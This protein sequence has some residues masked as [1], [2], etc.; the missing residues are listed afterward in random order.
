MLTEG[1]VA[2]LNAS[3]PLKAML[4]GGVSPVVLPKNSPLPAITYYGVSG[5]KD[6]ALDRAAVSTDS[7]DVNAW[8]KTYST[9]K[10]IQAQIHQLLDGYSG[11]L[12]DADATRVVAVTGNDTPD[13]FDQDSGLYRCTTMYSFATTN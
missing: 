3:A 4:S 2:L 7:I 13:S 1:I 5:K 10:Q 9:A 11:T 8:A 6:A 12:S